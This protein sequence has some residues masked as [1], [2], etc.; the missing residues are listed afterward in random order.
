MPAL[1]L[2]WR[3]TKIRY[4]HGVPEEHYVYNLHIE[5]FNTFFTNGILGH[6]LKFD[7]RDIHPTNGLDSYII[8]DPELG[9]IIPDIRP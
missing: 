4:R 8:Y 5:D 9:T 1:I 3:N 2:S 6:N 7:P